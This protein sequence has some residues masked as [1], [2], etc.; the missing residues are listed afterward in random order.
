LAHSVFGISGKFT[1]Q[2][3]TSEDLYKTINDD[4]RRNAQR[5][6]F[7]S[8]GEKHENTGVLTLE[9]HFSNKNQLNCQPNHHR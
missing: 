7:G 5:A 3:I 9:L 8:M 4:R 1:N 2:P 6:K